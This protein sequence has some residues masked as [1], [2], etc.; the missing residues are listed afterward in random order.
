MLVQAVRSP[1]T[2]AA[3][4]EKVA[5][6]VESAWADATSAPSLVQAIPLMRVESQY[7]DR[8]QTFNATREG[9]GPRAGEG[10]P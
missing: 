1:R 5:P 3:V 7:T 8:L 2:P 10:A 6:V 4:H 9:G